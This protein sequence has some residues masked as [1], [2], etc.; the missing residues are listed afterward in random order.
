M[1]SYRMKQYRG[2]YI[3]ASKIQ[4]RPAVI[5]LNVGGRRKRGVRERIRVALG[6]PVIRKRIR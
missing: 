2:R 3:W 5:W 1:P 6:V 4:G